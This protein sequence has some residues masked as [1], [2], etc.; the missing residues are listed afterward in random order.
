MYCTK[1]A[2]SQDSPA[3][4]SPAQEST[5]QDSPALFS[6]AQIFVEPLVASS[7]S[8]SNLIVGPSSLVFNSYLLNISANNPFNSH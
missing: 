1:F 2:S 5:A 8:S 7:S 3:Q 6:S 4:D